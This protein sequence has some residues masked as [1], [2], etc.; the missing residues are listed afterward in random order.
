MKSGVQ[1]RDGGSRRGF[2]LIEMLV[3]ISIIGILAS[4][5]MPS[6][7]K[8]REKARRVYC[9]NNLRQI[10]NAVLMYVADYDDWMPP[11][12]QGEF[13]TAGRTYV[14]QHGPDRFF[15]GCLLDS[16][17]L[18][19][20]KVMYCP[21]RTVLD[22]ND[23][24]RTTYSV[25]AMRSDGLTNSGSGGDWMSVSRWAEYEYNMKAYMSD[26]LIPS[27]YASHMGEGYNVLFGDGHV[28]WH[29]DPWRQVTK[30][31]EEADEDNSLRAQQ[32]IYQ[33]FDDRENPE[34]VPDTP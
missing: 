34:D 11:K 2:T 6:V 30:R 1:L 15:S 21:S 17:Y 28:V 32:E 19:T 22:T 3:V 13:P 31:M 9:M 18:G 10:H 27:Q 26:L 8:A 5:L 25:R 14:W 12:C 4:M 24:T 29:P 16:G 23:A 20:R 7:S 33:M